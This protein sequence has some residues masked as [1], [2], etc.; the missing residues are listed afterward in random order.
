MRRVIGYLKEFAGCVSEKDIIESDPMR[1][2]DEKNKKIYTDMLDKAIQTKEEQECETWRKMV[3]SCCEGEWL[4]IRTSVQLIGKSGDSYLFYAM[5][6]NIT[7]E[8]LQYKEMQNTIER[9][10]ILAEQADV[11]YWEYIINTQTVYPCER[12]ITERG[13]PEIVPNYPENAPKLGIVP[14][15]AA[16]KYRQFHEQLATGIKE[17]EII[18]PMTKKNLP[19]KVKY[20]VVF[21]EGGVPIKAYG[22]AIE[23]KDNK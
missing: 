8:K 10:R 19:H 6:R 15:E 9:F 13:L 4:C 16:E 2:F 14:P 11:Y 1:F 17:A 5:V 3:T 18:V 20:T 23:L 7:T 22:C 12:C 21:D